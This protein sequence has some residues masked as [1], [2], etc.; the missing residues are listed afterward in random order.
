MIKISQRQHTG[1]LLAHEHTS[2]ALL[3]FLILLLGIFLLSFTKTALSSD[4][5]VTAKVL[6]S[7]PT[8]SAIITDPVAGRHFTSPIINV[9]GVCPYPLL[10]E[11]SKNNIFAGS[12]ICTSNNTFSLPITL[13]EGKNELK[14]VDYDA[15]HQAGPDSGIVTVYYDVPIIVPINQNLNAPIQLSVTTD[16][17]IFHGKA[18][19]QDTS[20]TI[21]ISGGIPPYKINWDWGDG[22]IDVVNVSKLAMLQP[23]KKSNY[24]SIASAF[25]TSGGSITFHHN[26]KNPGSY[27]IIV[28]TTDNLGYQSIL[29]LV[30]IINPNTFCA[31]TSETTNK[32]RFN[33]LQLLH[34]PSNAKSIFIIWP[35]YALMFLMVISFWLGEKYKISKIRA[36]LP[37][38]YQNLH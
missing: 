36:L 11:V 32:T 9:S 22:T 15:F 26:Y 31:G 21:F 19:C 4:L 13:F 18:D 3:I 37:Y 17:Q 33:A 8:Q 24:L 28:R 14:A 20:W 27:K 29:A 5:L 12:T 30:A 35:I 16:A 1:K 34:L 25:A 23:R 7:P 38:R 2:Y 10:V 6:P